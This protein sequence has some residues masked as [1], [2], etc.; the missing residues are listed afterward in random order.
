MPPKPCSQ[1]ANYERQLPCGSLDLFDLSFR[2]SQ[3][4]RRIV[5]SLCGIA[6]THNPFQSASSAFTTV[7]ILPLS[8]SIHSHL[9]IDRCIKKSLSCLNP[10]LGY[11]DFALLYWRL[12]ACHRKQPINA[13]II[14]K[15]DILDNSFRRIHFCTFPHHFKFVCWPVT[16]HQNDSPNHVLLAPDLCWHW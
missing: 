1:F 7:A 6:M 14:D 11:N 5:S 15:S 2:S 4:R 3:E 16:L 10:L 9:V 8:S 13:T 12:P